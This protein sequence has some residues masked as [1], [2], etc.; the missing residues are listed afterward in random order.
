VSSLLP[1]ADFLFFSGAD[2][3][4]L[5]AQHRKFSRAVIPGGMYE[6]AITPADVLWRGR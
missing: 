4:I 1:Y 5:P 2:K 3:V 6:R